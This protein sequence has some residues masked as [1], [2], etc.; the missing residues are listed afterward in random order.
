MFSGRTKND[1]IL[2][3]DIYGRQRKRFLSFCDFN[4]FIVECV[5]RSSENMEG[6][7]TKPSDSTVSAAAANALI[8]K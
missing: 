3:G 7:L 2:L 8:P 1:E 6:L 4:E 5:L